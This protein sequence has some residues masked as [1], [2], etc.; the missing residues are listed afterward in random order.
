MGIEEEVVTTAEFILKQNSMGLTKEALVRLV[1]PRLPHRLLPAQIIGMLRKQPQR[2][3]EGGDGRWRLR[4]QVGL[5]DLEDAHEISDTTATPRRDLRQGCYVV[6]DLETI[7]RDASS[8]ATE[9]IQIA[10]WRWVDGV[11]EQPWATF[12][13]PSVTI[14]AEI[15]ELTD[16]SMDEVRDAPSAREAL[17]DFFAYVGDLPLIAHNGASFDGPIITAVCER[18]GLLC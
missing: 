10:A 12:V 2:F 11:P 13:H 9:I 5:G 14:P 3:V 6:F 17:T 15:E 18:L 7:G 1:E 4:E 16:I 8:P